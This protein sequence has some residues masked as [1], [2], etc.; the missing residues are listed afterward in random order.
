[1]FGLA[2][3][4]YKKDNTTIINNLINEN[5]DLK[6]QIEFLTAIAL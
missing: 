4:E 6:K 1:M 2:F 5:E 3:L